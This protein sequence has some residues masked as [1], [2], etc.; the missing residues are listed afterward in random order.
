MNR[1]SFK[2]HENTSSVDFEGLKS[3]FSTVDIHSTMPQKHSIYLHGEEIIINNKVC[4]WSSSKKTKI[5]RP[6]NVLKEFFSVG[7]QAS[8]KT[9]QLKK[10]LAQFKRS[11]IFLKFEHEQVFLFKLFFS[12]CLSE[13][14]E[15]IF[16]W[17]FVFYL[18]H[19]ELKETKKKLWFRGD[20]SF[21]SGG[22]FLFCLNKIQTTIPGATSVAPHIFWT[23]THAVAEVFLHSPIQCTWEPTMVFVQF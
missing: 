2:L 12:K 16:Q 4:S 9:L 1:E 5:C 15:T 17:N 21:C 10:I 23:S 20:D 8:S 19:Q 3:T 14:H 13:Q 6:I 18:K 11:L 7:L 22:W